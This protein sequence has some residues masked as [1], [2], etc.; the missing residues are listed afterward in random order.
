MSTLHGLRGDRLTNQ[1]TGAF[2]KADNWEAGII[3]LLIEP[4]QALHAGQIFGVHCADTPSALE[5][6]LERVFLRM[7][8]AWVCD[9]LS[10]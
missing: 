2:V 8:R 4:Q 3:R 1:K 9:K 7:V 6:R 5:V 10:Q